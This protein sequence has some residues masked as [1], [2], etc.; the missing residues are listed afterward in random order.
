[1]RLLLF[2]T[3]KQSDTKKG[4]SIHPTTGPQY[5]PL[6][7]L[8]WYCEMVQGKRRAQQTEV[9]LN[10]KLNQKRNKEIQARTLVTVQ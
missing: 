5:P 3:S 8:L 1:M 10:Q 9:K 4:T 2:C 6:Y 7:I